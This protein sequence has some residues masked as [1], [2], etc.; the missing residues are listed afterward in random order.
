[1]LI[2]TN[3]IQGQSVNIFI[4]EP[5]VKKEICHLTK[6]V[7]Y[8]LSGVLAKDVNKSL[9]EFA[10]KIVPFLGMLN[11][12]THRNSHTGGKKAVCQACGFLFF[13]LLTTTALRGR[14]TAGSD[15]C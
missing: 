9:K 14:T 2:L 12:E 11:T 3:A 15:G 13:G 10:L 7:M 1:M 8:F 6:H 4:K 5:A